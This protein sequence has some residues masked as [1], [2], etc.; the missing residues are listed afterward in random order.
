MNNRKLVLE[1]GKVFEG[2]GFGSTLEV[3]AEMIFNTAVVG[4]QEIISDP[5]NCNKIICMTYPLIGNYGLTDEDYESKHLSAKG[6]IVREYNEIPSNFR[7]TR[8]LGDVMEEFNI[9]GIS[10]IDT[11]YLMKVIQEEGSM[12]ALICDI[13]KPLDE[14][15]EV[16]NNYVEEENL[17]KLVSSKKMWYSRTPNPVFNVAVIDLGTKIRFIKELNNIG[18][19]VVVFPYNVTVEEIKKY[20][21]DGLFISNGPGNPSRLSGVVEIIKHFKNNL[22]IFGVGLGQLLIGL[23]YDVDVVK[24]KSGCHG[25]NYPVKDVETGKVE[26]TTQNYQYVLNEETLKKSS[27]EVSHIDVISNLSIGIVNRNDN[28]MGVL[29]EPVDPIDNDSENLFQE[30]LN[31]IKKCGGSKNA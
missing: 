7:Y 19:N 24:L 12:K 9:S 20:K 14:C 13:D 3:V 22:P 11:R 17:V 8:T 5:T 16:I 6:L 27:L 10:G 30:F 28:V 2:I 18:C 21:P 1:N 26:I 23:S 25:S 4:Y 15:M 29:F 31:V